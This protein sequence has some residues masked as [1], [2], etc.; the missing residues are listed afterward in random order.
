[1]TKVFSSLALVALVAGTA[2]AQQPVQPA[3]VTPTPV[4]GAPVA[5]D[6]IV[7]IVGDQ[8]IT[9][10]DLDERLLSL[11]QDPNFKMPTDPVAKRTLEKTTLDAMIDEEVLIAKAKAMKVEVPEADLNTSTDK[12]LKDVRSQF[13]SEA[14]YR[15]ALVQAGLGTPEE[16]R[17]FLNDQLRKQELQSRLFE[18]MKTDGKLVASNVTDKD[19]Q[20]AYDRIKAQGSSLKKPATV[21]MRQIVFNPTASDAAKAKA[22]AKAES[23]LVEIK[24]GA[25]FERVAKRESMDNTKELG[26]DL[27]WHRRGFFVPEFE[28]W[29][30][31]L[32]PG[33]ISPVVETPFGYHI[34]KVDRVQPSEVKSR[35]ILIRPVI[36][37]ND[38][39][40][41]HVL[42]D[43]VEKLWA[44]GAN[45]DT[46]A[47]KYHDY[48][49]QEE[50]S[51]LTPIARDS[52]PEAY[53]RAFRGHK[54]GDFSVFQI[55]GSVPEV[56]K[57]VAVQ[58]VTSDEG[59]EYSVN[60]LRERVRSQL[61]QEGAVRRFIDSL[62][63]QTYVS[64]RLD[65][66]VAT[67]KQ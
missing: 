43:S 22:K 31:A 20:E 66:A 67:S 59:G 47:K 34:I 1:M 5:L 21:T 37:S 27:G 15:T 53:Q 17:R 52:L 16:Y 44:A 63:K 42:A 56:P 60:D 46:L 11:Q 12:R 13:T 25:D 40:R 49:N 35:H 19:V 48:A 51:I 62:R 24:G 57:F 33:E 41:A 14:E 9:R 29:V 7:A 64:I 10:Y 3:P 58:L 36:D 54:A 55:P 6:R 2:A 26:G 39:K 28:R 61:A 8:P 45:F 4:A 30:F 50:T 32:P 38:I 23:L 65:D 18:K